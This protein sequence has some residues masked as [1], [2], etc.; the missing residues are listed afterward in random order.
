[1]LKLV[2]QIKDQVDGFIISG[3]RGTRVSAMLRLVTH[4][5]DRVAFNRGRCSS[6]LKNLRAVSVYTKKKIL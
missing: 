6:E 3:R 2:A 4:K 1:M 5:E